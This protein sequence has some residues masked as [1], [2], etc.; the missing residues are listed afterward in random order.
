MN[1]KKY[2]FMLDKF[3]RD[4]RTPKQRYPIAADLHSKELGEYYFV[5]DE[6]RVRSGADQPLISRFDENGIPV[7]KTYV[8]VTDKEYVYFPISIGQLGL[9]VFHTYLRTKSSEDRER[10]LQ[11]AEWYADE[12]N[13]HKDRQTGVRWLTDVSLPQ[14]RNKG[15]WQSAFSQSRGI[16]ILTRAFQ[17]SGRKEYSDI[18]G[19]A[20][21]CFRLPVKEGGVTVYTEKGPFYEEYTAAVPTLVLNGMIFALFGVYDFV[22]A[23]PENAQAAS[24]FAEGTETLARLL[25]EYDLG[26]W[27]RYNLCDAPWY[28]AVDPA[29]IAYQRL[30]VVQLQILYNITGK[31]IFNTYADI[32]RRQ[33]TLPNALT[34]YM[35]KQ[36]ALKKLGR[37]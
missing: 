14:Y 35:Q 37:L 29:T 2:F 9:A 22:R 5:F 12:R 21:T 15:P 1:I 33:D 27:S 26:Y 30:H 19:A 10:F 7:N 32:F 36:K 16:S 28:P 4:I 24:I 17:I 3:C 31:E 34:M 23:F 8:D 13:Y 20:L 18:A 11:F 25:P 6:E